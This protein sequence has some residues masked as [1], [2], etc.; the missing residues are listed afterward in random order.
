MSSSP[1]PLLF[2]AALALVAP[3][4]VQAQ[5]HLGSVTVHAPS[6]L[7]P[8]HRMKSTTV[9]FGDLNL[10]TDSGADALITRLRT[11][12]RRVC[13]PRPRGREVRVMDDYQRCLKGAMDD[14]VT[15]ISNPAV[16]AAYERAR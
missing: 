7:Q 9:R 15:S 8:D 13:A 6:P 1:I 2:A 5:T 14:A 16:Q 3:A 4:A 10:Q 12:A 11:A